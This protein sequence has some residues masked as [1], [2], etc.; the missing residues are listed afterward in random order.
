[1]PLCIGGCPRPPRTR[2][3]TNSTP[4]GKGSV[5]ENNQIGIFWRKGFVITLFK[6]RS[7]QIK[8]ALAGL[9]RKT[10]LLKSPWACDR[11]KFLNFLKWLCAKGTEGKANEN[12]P[13]TLAGSCNS[14]RPD[15]SDMRSLQSL[16]IDLTFSGGN[17]KDKQR[18]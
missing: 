3:I 9:V 10:I 4:A 17:E 16:T 7:H 8:S 13:M 2:A 18:S 5:R 15:L 1:M 6:M 12:F 14:T 11:W